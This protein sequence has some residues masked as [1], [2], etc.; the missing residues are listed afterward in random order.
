M[1]DPDAQ[2]LA[3]WA[4]ARRWLNKADEDIRAADLMLLADP[5]LVDQAAFHC[6]QAAEKIIKGLL[7]A[8]AVSAP[9]IHDIERLAESAASLYPAFRLLMDEFAQTTAWNAATRYPDL[10]MSLGATGSDV[11]EILSQ[12]RFFRQAAGALDPTPP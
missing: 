1:S 8:A 5:P 7:V 12:L 2:M 10:G 3:Q 4:D 11:A 9:R 6:Q